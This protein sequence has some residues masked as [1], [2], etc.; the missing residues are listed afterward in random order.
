MNKIPNKLYQTDKDKNIP[1]KLQ[2]DSGSWKI[3]NP[4]LEFIFMDDDD[5]IE[6]IKNNFDNE[7]FKA[8]MSLPLGIMKADFWRIAII[9]INGGIYADL[10][11]EMNVNINDLIGEEQEEFFINDYGSTGNFIFAA[12]PKHPILKDVLDDMV[13]LSSNIEIIE[14]AQIFGIHPLQRAVKKYFDKDKVFLNHEDLKEHKKLQ[15]N[16]IASSNGGELVNA[17]YN[18]W[19]ILQ[20][21]MIEER[22]NTKDSSDSRRANI[23]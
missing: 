12:K 7:T 8:Y 5:C 2:K 20:D 4:N 3:S 9:Y 15:H 17:N 21:I 16:E 22:K 18:S 1:F 13:N 23:T 6:F 14:K 10:D 19:R 11:V